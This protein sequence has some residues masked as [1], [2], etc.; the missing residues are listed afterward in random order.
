MVYLLSVGFFRPFP[1]RSPIGTPDFRRRL[2]CL[3]YE[4]HFF[5]F[6]SFLDKKRDIRYA[7]ILCLYNISF[8]FAIKKETQRYCTNGGVI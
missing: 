2:R 3:E 4:L 7:T 6:F 8:L 1:C 5:L